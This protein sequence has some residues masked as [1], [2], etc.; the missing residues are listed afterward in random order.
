MKLI[1]RGNTYD[2]HPELTSDRTAP[3]KSINSYRTPY[4]L[5]YRGLSYT[6]DPNHR[7][8]EAPRPTSYDLQ[9][10]GLTYHVTRDAQGVATMT[11][12]APGQA[13]AKAK[14]TPAS[15]PRNNTAKVHKAN[16]LQ[17]VQRRL[18]V[19]RERGDQE[20]IRLLEAEL[21]QLTA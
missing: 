6:V 8:V 13:Q 3:F 5:I 11:T 4:T 10:R 16:L 12:K 1:Y 20:L 19:A 14:A 2:Y 21:N 7:A 17:N 15:L 18:Q 9:Y